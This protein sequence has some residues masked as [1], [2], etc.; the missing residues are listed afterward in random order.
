MVKL[1]RCG[2]EEYR[3]GT[4]VMPEARG[5]EGTGSVS[6]SCINSLLKKK[7]KKKQEEKAQNTYDRATASAVGNRRLRYSL[8]VCN[9][10]Q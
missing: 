7:K 1:Q 9:C 2:K 10:R 3:F 6:Y 4:V 5:T 8:H